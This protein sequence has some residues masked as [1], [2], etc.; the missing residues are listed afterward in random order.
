MQLSDIFDALARQANQ[1]VFVYS[2]ATR[3]LEYLNPAFEWIWPGAPADCRTNPG[4]L[5]AQVHPDDQE[6]LHDAF[7]QALRGE[8]AKNVEFRLRLTDGSDRWLCVSP[9]RIQ[10]PD[11]Q[12][13]I[14]GFA[15]EI[16]GGKHY[17][18]V[19]KKYA[20]KKN[21]ILEILSHDLAGPLGTIQ[22]LTAVVGKR[23]QQY[24]DPELE[25]FVALISQMAKRNIHLIREFVK[26]EFLESS[27]A[28]VI[29]L[30]VDLVA[31]TREVIEQYQAAEQNIAKQFHLEVSADRIYVEIDEVKFMQAV[32]NLISNA[33]KFT[34][35]NGIITTR[36]SQEADHVI[37]SVADNGIGIPKH[38]Q[39]GLFDKFTK[40]RRP[41]LRGEESVGLGM[42]VIKTIVG[43]HGGEIWFESRENEGS[44]FYIRLPEGLTKG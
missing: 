22:G 37:L 34:H 27:S 2:L 35:D 21:S 28:E 10:Q 24:N 20:A 4:G 8:P 7:R 39:A 29:K 38:L 26:Q 25:E 23:I 43:W 42:S 44:T 6:Y 41:G 13:C 17:N 30:R 16:T 3:Q 33:I 11:G 19:L 18:D 9:F 31:K 40:A 32:N 5:L 12:P 14:A 1:V 36:I 15:S